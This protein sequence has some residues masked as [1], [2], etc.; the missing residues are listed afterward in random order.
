MKLYQCGCDYAELQ[1]Q[2][3]G[4]T[5]KGYTLVTEC[6]ECAAK[7]EAENIKLEEEKAINKIAIDKE[8]LIQNKMRELAINELTIEGKL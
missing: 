2:A 5:V 6:S 1:N 3:L 4:S 7:R 8:T